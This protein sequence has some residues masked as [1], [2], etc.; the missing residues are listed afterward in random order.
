MVSMLDDDCNRASMDAVLRLMLRI[1]DV[2]Q[3]LNITVATVLPKFVRQIEQGC[4][5]ALKAQVT[6]PAASGRLTDCDA[7]WA[8]SEYV[9]SAN[10]K[11]DPN[12]C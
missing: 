11:S 9:L 12:E 3:R 10:D 7:G 8:Q 1:K 2:G 5:R 6:R 4:H